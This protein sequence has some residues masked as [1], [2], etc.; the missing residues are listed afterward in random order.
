VM[1]RATSGRSRP[2]ASRVGEPQK[3]RDHRGTAAGQGP[4]CRGPP[5][6]VPREYQSLAAPADRGARDKWPTTCYP[7]GESG[8]STLICPR[9]SEVAEEGPEES[10]GSFLLPQSELQLRRAATRSTFQ[11]KT[12]TRLRAAVRRVSAPRL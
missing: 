2:S 3:R 12:T 11:S 7:N 5:P 8:G 1:V 6:E 4:R 10:F 9:S